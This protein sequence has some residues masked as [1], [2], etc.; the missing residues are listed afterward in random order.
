MRRCV[1]NNYDSEANGTNHHR[2]EEDESQQQPF[3]LAYGHRHSQSNNHYHR[4]EHLS[5]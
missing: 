1:T 5:K 4:L 3:R 2:K